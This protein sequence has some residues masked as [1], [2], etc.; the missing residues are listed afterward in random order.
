VHV[1]S[2][3]DLLEFEGLAHFCEHMLFMGTTKFP[4]ENENSE[5]ISNHSG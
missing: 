3:Y 4:R 2:G 1:G 5:F